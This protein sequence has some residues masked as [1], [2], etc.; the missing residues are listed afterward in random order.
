MSSVTIS[1]ITLNQRHHLERLLPTLRPA[2]ARCRA[3]VRL[4]DNRSADNSSDF[5]RREYPEIIITQ[6]PNQAGYGAN[7]N[8]N[9]RQSGTDYFVIMNSDMMVEK[10]LFS[11]LAEF[12][13]ANP[14]VGI[15]SPRVLNE[16]GTIQGL[17]KRYPTLFDLVARKFFPPSLQNRFR[18]KLDAYEMRDVGYDHQYDVPLLSGAFMFCRTDLLKKLAGFDES[19]FLYFEDFDLCRRVQKTHRTVYYPDVSVI[20]FWERA[21]RKSW[22]YSMYFAA[23]AFRYFQRWGWR[24]F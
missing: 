6:N 22:R 18:Q 8:I 23:G 12:M 20:H 14:D 19:F 5:V 15:V 4:V 21:T 24:F 10:N 11:R 1:L 3:V 2:A 9:L 13:D 17:N 16:D 7:H